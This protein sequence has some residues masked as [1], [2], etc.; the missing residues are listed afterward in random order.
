MAIQSKRYRK[1]SESVQDLHSYDLDEA[2][3][4]LKNVI[5]MYYMEEPPELNAEANFAWKDGRM[6]TWR[7]VKQSVNIVQSLLE[8]EENDGRS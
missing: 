7:D 3:T 8:G 6:S 5:E 4:I 2:I 1:S